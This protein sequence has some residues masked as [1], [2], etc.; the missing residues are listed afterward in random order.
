MKMAN[1]Q[2]CACGGIF[3]VLLLLFNVSSA[4]AD[5]T[6]SPCDLNPGIQAGL[7]ASPVPGG[8]SVTTWHNKNEQ[9]SGQQENDSSSTV[10]AQRA[11]E[12]ADSAPDPRALVYEEWA[13]CKAQ[14]PRVRCGKRAWISTPPRT[15]SAT[16]TPR[17][18]DGARCSMA[19][20]RMRI[21]RS[22]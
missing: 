1:R 18:R 13:R 10:D 15:S 5:N 8:I 22:R 17:P 4:F 19:H 12:T 14:R 6:P 16:T 2:L 7:C 9:S 11:L 3:G 20:T 21:A